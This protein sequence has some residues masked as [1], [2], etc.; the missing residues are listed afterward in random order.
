MEKITL[1]HSSGASAEVYHHGAHIT[2]WKNPSGKELIFVSKDAIFKPPKAIRGGVPVCFPQFNDMGNTVAHGFARNSA[3][4]VVKA[5]GDTAVLS[6]DPTEEQLKSYPFP[7]TLQ[8]EITLDDSSLTSVM[9]VKNTG[10]TEMQFTTALH[11]YLA[12]SDIANVSVKGLGAVD[13]LDNCNQRVKCNDGVECVKIEKETDR[14][15]L[16]APDSITVED[17]GHGT[18]VVEKRNLPDAVLWNPWVAKA[19]ATADFGDDEWHN[20]VCLEPAQAGSGP[21]S[22]APGHT[23]SCTQK[24]TY[25][26]ASS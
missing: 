14:I 5:E 15:Y 23:W 25:T 7:F 19:K 26:A 18:F 16:A 8:M 20:M 6:L 12:I 21:A 11:T 22:L 9:T 24:L 10:S 1:T 13:Y 17:E 3:W 2:S 4:T